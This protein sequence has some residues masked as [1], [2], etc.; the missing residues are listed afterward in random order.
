MEESDRLI[1]KW[2]S[3]K[4]CSVRLKNVKLHKCDSKPVLCKVIVDFIWM[5]VKPPTT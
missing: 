1:W 3:N 4:Y 5:K 2:D